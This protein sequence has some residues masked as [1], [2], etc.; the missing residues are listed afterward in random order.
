[1]STDD[2]EPDANGNSKGECRN[3]HRPRGEIRTQKTR[4]G[5]SEQDCRARYGEAGRDSLHHNIDET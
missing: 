3:V 1:M 2:E 5:L 4:G